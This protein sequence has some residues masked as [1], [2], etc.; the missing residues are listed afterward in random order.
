MNL[1]TTININEA[2]KILL[3][4]HASNAEIEL[5]FEYID[6]FPKHQEL[7]HSTYLE[8]KNYIF[9]FIKDFAQYTFSPGF[10]LEPFV[11][12]DVLGYLIDKTRFNL[13]LNKKSGNQILYGLDHVKIRRGFI[14]NLAHD[15]KHKILQ[16]K[17]VYF[18]LDKKIKAL[19]GTKQEFVYL[20]FEDI[21]MGHSVYLVT[22]KFGQQTPQ[23]IVVKNGGL[24]YQEFFVHLLRKLSWPSYLSM[25][26]E[27]SLGKWEIMAYIAPDNMNDYLNQKKISNELIKQLGRH[28]ALGDILGR[29]DRHL[30]N[31]IVKAQKVFPVD[32]TFLFWEG[33]ETWVEKY[34]SGGA[35]EVNAVGDN[36]AKLN[37]FFSTYAQAYAELK[38]KSSH[39]IE[40]ITRFFNAKD[41]DTQRKIKYVQ[42]RLQNTQYCARQKA[43]YLK[44]LA[45]AQ[46]RQPYKKM[47]DQ[48]YVKEGGLD[49]DLLKMYYLAN[50][51]RTSSFFLL[52]ERENKVFSQIQ[53]LASSFN[54]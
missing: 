9:E 6:Y 25:H 15:F 31:Y 30:E 50:K 11:L 36:P 21:G 53:S 27:D 23:K 4:S 48:I 49:D 16:D 17:F 38:S 1:N 20:D 13:R 2:A 12:T 29:G 37:L 47:L 32:I 10:G 35:Y 28:A 46:R 26:F 3:S 7:F 43:S 14:N 52:E 34:I 8:L 54:I 24:K 51:D 18:G 22:I 33:N 5:F 41:C 39:I 40:M 42:S 44:G 19:Y 45:E